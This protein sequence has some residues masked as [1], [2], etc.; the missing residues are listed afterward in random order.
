VGFL[1]DDGTELPEHALAAP[2]TVLDLNDRV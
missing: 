2:A 1:G